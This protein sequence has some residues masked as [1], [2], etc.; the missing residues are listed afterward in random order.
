[1]K[2]DNSQSI[3][4]PGKKTDQ[5]NFNRFALVEWHRRA[6]SNV[7]SPSIS[8]IMRSARCHQIRGVSGR[9]ANLPVQL[10][11]SASEITEMERK[12]LGRERKVFL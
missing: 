2:S 5:F 8:S 10:V 11:Q 12:A 6:K 1:M 7:L 9:A 3:L 4:A